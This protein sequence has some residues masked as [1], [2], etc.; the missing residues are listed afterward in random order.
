MSLV[1]KNEFPKY[2]MV[3]FFR[4]GPEVCILVK[5]GSNVLSSEN[6]VVILN[7]M[8]VR[9]IFSQSDWHVFSQGGG[10]EWN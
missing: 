6:S 10:G 5:P 3:F 8:Q 2:I 9:F 4:T 1:E 7:T